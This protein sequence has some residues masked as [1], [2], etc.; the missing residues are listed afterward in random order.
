MAIYYLDVDDEITSAAA[1]I[2]DSSDSRIALVLSVGSRVATSRINFRLL[3]GEAKHRNKRLAII[4]SDPSVQSVARSAELPVYASVGDYEKAEM[5]VAGASAVSGKTAIPVAGALDELALTMSAGPAPARGA[6]RGAT[7]IPGAPPPVA[8]STREKS[9]VPWSMIA[10]VAFLILVLLAASGFFFFPGATVV[11][12]LKGESLGPVTVSVKVDPAAAA[13]NYQAGIVPGVRKNFPVQAADTFPATGQNVVETAATGTV[14]FTSIDTVSAVTVITGTQIGTANGIEFTTTSTVNVPKATVSGDHITRGT[15]DAPVIAVVKGT[16]GNVPAGSIVKE[17]SDLATFG[18]SVTN[19]QATTG[20][21]REVTPKVQQSDIDAAEAAMWSKLDTSFQTAWKAPGAAPSGSRLFAESANLGVATCS[22]DPNG[23]LDQVAATF[24][25]DC[26][27][28]GSVTMADLTAVA[29]LVK[30]R[31]GASVKSGY[32]LV[33]ASLTTKTALGSLQGSALVLPVT[34]QGIQVP[35]L[36]PDV[37]RAAIKG[38]S[39]DEAKVYLSQFGDVD[40]SMFPGWSSTMPSFDFRLDIQIVDP[41]ATGAASPN[42]G[43]G[44]SQ[45]T[46]APAQRASG[47]PGHTAVPSSPGESTPT[48]GSI[49]TPTPAPS[50]TPIG[51]PSAS[52]AGS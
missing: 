15:A 19:K 4:A 50:D 26:R 29:D 6:V 11:L 47:T 36:D 39:V 27:A 22:P 34:A 30:K 49:P 13:T 52:P 21:T 45:P 41:T 1:R 40:I 10:G 24:Q 28:T 37:L 48:P 8:G 3:A 20:G 17:P 25:L 14:T 12:T 51:S 35:A 33:D 43:A 18:I 44:T 7:R 38:K 9:R 46:K 31:A 42:A 16:T 32:S 5:A 2:R 23:L